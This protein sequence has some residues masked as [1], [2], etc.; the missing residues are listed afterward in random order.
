MIRAIK[1]ITTELTFRCNAACP[2]CHRQKPLSIDL[3]DKIHTITLDN[4]K[5]LFYPELLNNL[6][7]LILNGNFGDSIMN[8]HFREI[9]K[10]V[11]LH[12]TRI[13]IHT[14]GGVHNTD[15][16][17]DVGNILT[18]HDIINFDLDGL[19]D[20]HSKYRVNTDFS[21]VLANACAVIATKRAKV[22]WKYIVF[23]HNKHQV[24]EARAMAIKLG[25]N[26]FSTVKTSRDT[27][28]P[29]S[30][31]FIHSKKTEEYEKA[32]RKIH[33]VWDTYNKWYIS[34]EGLVFRCCWTGGHYY[35]ES[36]T[37]FYYPP[38]FEE[39]FNGFKVP[40]EQILNYSYWDKLRNFLQGYER[41]FKLCKSQCGK[42][43]SSIEKLEENLDNNTVNYIDVS[44]QSDN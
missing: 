19:Q 35:D 37:R 1:Q 42:I 34:P 26:T 44:N 20:T 14:N 5:K 8:K 33:C 25:F 7:W 28:A 4:F 11:K 30:G 9:I 17:T 18:K 39:L 29:T 38:N 32:E 27:F 31:S 10:Y 23:E 2:A 43:V 21:K 3:N 36:N 22:H 6:E 24:D 41:S 16:W 12:G 15:Y 13:L 40:I